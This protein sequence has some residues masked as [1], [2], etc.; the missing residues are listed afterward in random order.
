MASECGAV[1]SGRM[2]APAIAEQEPNL[3]TRAKEFSSSTDNGLFES[4]QAIGARV[5]GTSQAA[6]LPITT[7]P[8]GSILP[9]DLLV[10]TLSYLT[11]MD[12]WL[13]S[14]VCRWWQQLLKKDDALRAQVSINIACD[15]ITTT[16]M[17]LFRWSTPS[18]TCSWAAGHGHLPLLQWLRALDFSWN[19]QTCAMA[20]YNGHLEVLQWLH[21]NGCPWDV[22]TC[23]RAA[24]GGHLAILQW[25][26]ANSC[27]LN[28][29]ACRVAARGG[30][31]AVLQWLRANGCPWDEDTSSYAATGGHLVILQWLRA[32][33]CPWNWL[34][35][36]AAEYNGHQHVADWARANGCPED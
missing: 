6:P 5:S 35:I 18:K 29:W 4:S 28:E 11:P 32:N 25:S 24:Q 3:W 33:N 15:K 20:A 16:I 2:R 13:A 14:Q 17:K 34:T 7:H 27:S 9:L 36:R 12:A 30:H 1:G 19:E 22:D 21:A 31:L 8:A 26:H 23:A 10:E